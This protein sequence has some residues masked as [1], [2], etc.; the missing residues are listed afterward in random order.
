MLIFRIFFLAS[1]S[2]VTSVMKGF[3][4]NYSVQRGLFFFANHHLYR[5]VLPP[6]KRPGE[7]TSEHYTECKKSKHALLVWKFP[8]GAGDGK[9]E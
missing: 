2:K 1:Q 8:V 3:I 4:L 5:K 6:A 7:S 9:K